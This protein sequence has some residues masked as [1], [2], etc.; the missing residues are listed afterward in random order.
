MQS[1]DEPRRSWGE[2]ETPQD[3]PGNEPRSGQALAEEEDLAN[4]KREQLLD[5]AV[6]AVLL[7]AI[8]LGGLAAIIGSLVIGFGMICHYAT[9]WGYLKP[10]QVDQI[11]DWLRAIGVVSVPFIL[12]SLYSRRRD[13]TDRR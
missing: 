10:E 8:V 7:I 12:R 5:D 6:N 4:F 2:S 3:S 13:R 9:P 1:E 11:E